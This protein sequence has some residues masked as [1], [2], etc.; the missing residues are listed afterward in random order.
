M[1][2]LVIWDRLTTLATILEVTADSTP[3]MVLMVVMAAGTINGLCPPIN[4]KVTL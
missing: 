3:A 4:P 1:E 2:Y